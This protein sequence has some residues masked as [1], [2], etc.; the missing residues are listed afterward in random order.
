ML[1]ILET[2]LCRGSKTYRT[3]TEHVHVTSEASSGWSH[4]ALIPH[5]A[6][7]RSCYGQCQ[8]KVLQHLGQKRPTCSPTMSCELRQQNRSLVLPLLPPPRPRPGFRVIG[9]MWSQRLNNGTILFIEML[10]TTLLHDGTNAAHNPPRLCD[11]VR[12]HRWSYRS[13]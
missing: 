10:L 9:L 13:Q 4:D 11:R 8:D 3:R 12:A 1:S 6:E 2:S 7:G 5:P